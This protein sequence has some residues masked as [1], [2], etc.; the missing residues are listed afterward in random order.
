MRAGENGRQMSWKKNY[1]FSALIIDS[2]RQVGAT[3]NWNC[4]ELQ[5]NC[6]LFL[7]NLLYV[8]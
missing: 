4:K 5:I 2:F 6:M 3:L 8:Y 1:C 7:K